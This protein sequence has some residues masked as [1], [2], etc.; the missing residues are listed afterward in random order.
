MTATWSLH[1]QIKIY[2]KFP[3]SSKYIHCIKAQSLYKK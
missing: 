1:G 3:K 2:T